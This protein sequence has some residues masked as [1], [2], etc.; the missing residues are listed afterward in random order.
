MVQK[1][2]SVFGALVMPMLAAALLIMN[3]RTAWVGRAYR[4]RWWTAA[5]L[6]GI[7]LFFAVIGG[8]QLLDIVQG[9]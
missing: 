5:M 4:N 2:N 7:L 6:A 8:P 3:G 1:L 9:K